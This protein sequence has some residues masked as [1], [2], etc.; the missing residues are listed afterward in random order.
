MAEI[1]ILWSG[2][3]GQTRRIVQVLED[4]VKEA[5]HRLEVVNADAPPTH[6]F[7]TKPDAL[8]VVAWGEGGEYSPALRAALKRVNGN[9]AAT[10]TGFAA[11]SL[12]AA[13]P[14]REEEAEDVAAAFLASVGWKPTIALSAAG[15]LRYPEYEGR[16]RRAMKRLARRLGLPRDTSRVHDFTDWS[17]VR[18]FA[19][20]LM[21]L[22]TARTPDNRSLDEEVGQLY[23]LA[24]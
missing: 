16:Q 24:G 15:A 14:G 18:T 20:Q 12:M 17:R 22:A 6:A 9:L 23:D 10:P 2:V 19:A 7:F 8:V 5:G 4:A 11:V 3:D 13:V 21:A 1:F